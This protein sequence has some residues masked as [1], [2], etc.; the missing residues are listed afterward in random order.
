MTATLLLSTCGTSLLTNRASSDE[1]AWLIQRAN[2][3]E[4]PADELAQLQTL[5]DRVGAAFLAA[6]EPAARLLSA[7]Y[8]GIRAV[9]PSD[10][11]RAE[12]WLVHTDTVQGEATAELLRARLE[13]EG[14]RVQLLSAGGLRTHDLASFREAVAELTA[15][16]G[17]T[18]PGYR[19]SGYRIVFNLTGG[20][21]SL[22]G[23]LQALGMLWADE[24]TYLFE[25]SQEAIRIPRLP[26]RLDVTDSFRA[27]LDVFRRL[28]VGYRLSADAVAG[29]PETLLMQLGDDVG[30]S[31]WADA[32]WPE[33][34][35]Q[36]LGESLLAPLSPRVELRPAL[37]RAAEQLP[38]DR[39]TKLNEALDALC[40]RLDSGRA[41]LKSE[42]L[43][44]I[45]SG[46]RL[47]G[48]THE[49]YAWSDRDA[50]RLF[51]HFE[52][53]RCVVDELGEHLR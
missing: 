22:N 41:A 42:K 40:G 46:T 10:S 38:P 48:A 23:Y 36:L 4:L 18:L 6:D 13:A 30:P 31:V 33:A 37:T 32:L 51:L 53:E 12:H 5:V 27:H 49:L 14:A 39:R 50:K 43:E 35:K 26:I 44:K 17:E 19:E 21:K 52:G 29:V 45:V 25:S 7:E 20:F 1:R 24:C 47:S 16:F 34:K 15:R 28:A 2:I 3:R 8:N 9:L 11:A